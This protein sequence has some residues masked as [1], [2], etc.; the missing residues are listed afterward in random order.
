MSNL[1]VKCC[2]MLNGV[3]LVIFGLKYSMN[4]ITSNRI[5]F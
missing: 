5:P 2:E 1:T 3:C 4:I